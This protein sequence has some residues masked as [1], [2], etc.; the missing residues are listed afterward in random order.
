[1]KRAFFLL[2]TIYILLLTAVSYAMSREERVEDAQTIINLFEQQYAPMDWKRELWGLDFN[3][4]S[5]KLLNDAANAQNDKEFYYAVIDFLASF[6]DGH[7]G[8]QIMSS[9]KAYLPFGAKCFSDG[10]LISE[11]NRDL[12]PDEKTPFKV[13]DKLIAIDGKSS[14]DILDEIIGFLTNGYEP[15][16][17]AWLCQFLTSRPQQYFPDIPTG[18][19]NITILPQGSNEP[20][21]VDLKWIT[22]GVSVVEMPPQSAV[23]YM[24]KSIDTDRRYSNGNYDKIG[25]DGNADRQ[26][27]PFFGIWDNFKLHAK[28][29]FLT[30]TFELNGRTI[31]FIRIDTWDDDDGLPAYS[32]LTEFFEKEVK[33]FINN[34]DAL[35]IDQ[36]NNGGG[37]ICYMSYSVAPFFTT[38]PRNEIRLEVRANRLW[39]RKYGLGSIGIDKAHNETWIKEITKAIENGDRLTKPLPFCYNSGSILPYRDKG[40]NLIHYNKPVLLLVNEAS[41]SAADM[42]PAMMKDWDVMT[43]FGARTG[44]GGGTIVHTEYLGHSELWIQLTVSMEYREKAVLAP[45]GTYTHYIENVGVTP[46][47]EYETTSEDFL[48]GYANYRKAVEGAILDLIGK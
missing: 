1:M 17:R 38:I 34:T 7:I 16:D 18:D 19:A 44:G 25:A 4:N 2:L 12:L 39:L 8:Y 43:L 31:G 35:I 48:D 3:A 33:F 21:S 27:L 5:Q 9:Y 11:I 20:I 13:G 42:F 23:G 36:T 24:A 46:E 22:K 29:P 15:T 45:N 14:E 26:M 41:F 32:D 40:N 37:S 10:I 47:I 6:K 30:G 28:E